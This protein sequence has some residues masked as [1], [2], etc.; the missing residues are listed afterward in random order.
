MACNLPSPMYSNGDVGA[1]LEIASSKY[2][3]ALVSAYLLYITSILL[4]SGGNSTASV[5]SSALV[6]LSKRP[7][8]PLR[9]L[10]I[11]WWS[12]NPGA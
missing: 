3:A 4:C 1:G 11:R 6:S 7:P 5:I 9:I 10:I 2:I 12:Y 8:F